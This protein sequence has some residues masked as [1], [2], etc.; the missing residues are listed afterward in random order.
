MDNELNNL[1]KFN[2]LLN[3]FRKVERV[4][5]ANDRDRWENDVEHS[6]QLAMLAWY[7]V[8][9]K[10]LNLDVN[11]VVRYALVHD[12]V[13]VYAGDTFFYG[14]EKELATKEK[15]EKDALKKLKK[16][17]L[18]FPDMIDLVEDYENKIDKESKFIYALD[19]IEPILNIY[20]D[21]GRTWKEKD[22]TI[23]MLYSKKKDKVAV[24]PTIKKYF[25]SII[26]LLKKEEKQLFN[27]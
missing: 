7:I 8:S 14:D 11:K 21:G 27:V 24:D 22:I 5:R 10:K 23:D 25:D 2:Q 1:F 12:F 9:S 20:Q 19:K 17:L 15:R 4:V 6:Y 26:E 3:D 16:E 13:E 18:E